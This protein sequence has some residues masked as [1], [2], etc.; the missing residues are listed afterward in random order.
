MVL[1]TICLNRLARK[2]R[3]QFAGNRN[4]GKSSDG[5]VEGATRIARLP[6]D[7]RIACSMR[8]RSRQRLTI[9]KSFLAGSVSM[10]G[11]V[12]LWARTCCAG[13]RRGRW[14]ELQLVAS[15]REHVGEQGIVFFVRRCLK[16]CSSRKKI[17]LR[18]HQFHAAIP[19]DGSGAPERHASRLGDVLPRRSQEKKYIRD[20]RSLKRLDRPLNPHSAITYPGGTQMWKRPPG[21]VGRQPGEPSNLLHRSHANAVQKPHQ[22]KA[23]AE[24][25]RAGR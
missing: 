19:L 12:R 9:S 23:L 25:V 6:R 4:C 7:A 14:R 20:Q 15:A 17:V 18:T 21:I 5:N 13:P 24:V 16:N 10:P 2:R 1:E 11:L 8:S 22:P 3:D